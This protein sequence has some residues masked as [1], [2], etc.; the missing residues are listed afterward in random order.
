MSV[1]YIIGFDGS[2]PS[3]A[4]LAW[5][6]RRVRHEP[7]PIVLVHVAEGDSGAMGRA[8]EDA[9]MREGAALLSRRIDALR[10][11]DPDL[12]VEGLA[13]EGSVPWELARTVA[14][15]DLLVVGTHKTG[16]L[17]GRVL[18]SRSVQIAAVARCNVAVVPETDLRFRSGVVAGIDRA[19][20]A[21]AV[22]RTAAAEAAARGDELTLVQAVPA[23]APVQDRA[24]L[25][26]A[27]VA[28]RDAQPGLVIRSRISTRPPAEALLDSARDKALLVL[29]PG[30]NKPERSPIGSVLHDVLLNV[31]A[32]VVVARASADVNVVA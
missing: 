15:H 29:G 27:M 3:E 26:V 5:V 13:L 24:P 12:D 14:P 19:E 18:G 32:P 11:S 25:A 22:A 30:S 31:N 21:D 20:T 7:G 1:R 17:H 28:A 8:F 16:F 6:I 23:G 4:A 10:H 9:D 2:S